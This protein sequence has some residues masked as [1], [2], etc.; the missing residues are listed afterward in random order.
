[1]LKIS[2]QALSCP[3]LAVHVQPVE[4]AAAL[5][6]GF[7]NGSLFL[8]GIFQALEELSV[9]VMLQLSGTACRMN[10]PAFKLN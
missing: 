8:R 3:A 4:F 1:M 2:K 9:Q 6:P 7:K 10:I 5:T